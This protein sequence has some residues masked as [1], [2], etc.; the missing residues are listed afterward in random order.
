MTLRQDCDLL[1]ISNQQSTSC[2]VSPTPSILFWHF[3]ILIFHRWAALSAAESFSATDWQVRV[4]QALCLWFRHYSQ[5]ALCGIF[6]RKYRCVSGNN[7]WKIKYTVGVYSLYLFKIIYII[8]SVYPASNFK[9][10]LSFSS[11]HSFS[12]GQ[13][14][15]ACV[16]FISLALNGRSELGSGLCTGGKTWSLHW[17]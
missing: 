9:M 12:G 4:F 17:C 5:N 6:R 15:S 2:S 13:W 16:P 7:K 10:E 11:I 8:L 1:P 14:G 3:L